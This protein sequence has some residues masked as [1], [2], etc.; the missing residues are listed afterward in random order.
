MFAHMKRLHFGE[1]VKKKKMSRKHFPDMAANEEEYNND[2]EID[3]HQN[4]PRHS[5]FNCSE[6][7]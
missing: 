6:Y 5:N 1:N 2:Y 3:D 7:F 4:L